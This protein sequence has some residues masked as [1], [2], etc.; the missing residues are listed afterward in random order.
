M[1]EKEEQLRQAAEK[2]G[3]GSYRRHVFLCTGPTCCT[4]EVGLAAWEELKR[5]HK[6]AGLGAGEGACYRTKVGCLRI[7]CHGP[8]L[9]V[10]PEGT[11]YSGMTADRIGRLVREH[12]VEGRPVEE[13]VFARNPIGRG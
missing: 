2:L 4:P 1:S 6:A 12:L 13:W 7:C 5:Q 3:I 10:Y 8:T 11:W 9:V